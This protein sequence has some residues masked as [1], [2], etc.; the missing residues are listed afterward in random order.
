M[1]T[2]LPL[3]ASFL[4]EQ[5]AAL[6]EYLRD[7]D[8]D[9][10]DRLFEDPLQAVLGWP[11]LDV[12]LADRTEVARGGGRCSVSGYYLRDRTPPRIRI[13]DALSMGRRHFTA[14]HE[15]AHHLQPR[16]PKIAPL[17]AKHDKNDPHRTL[18]DRICDAFAAEVLLPDE[19]V[20]T[21]I[22]SAHGPDAE[23]VI[24][25]YRETHASRAA[26]CVRAAQR[27]DHEGWVVL[28]DLDGVVQFAAAANLK[29][30]LAPGTQ[31]PDNSLITRA[32]AIGHQQ[33]FTSVTY[34]SGNTSGEFNTD[35]RTA[36]NFVFTV[37]SLGPTPWTEFPVPEDRRR[38][39]GVESACDH[40]GNEWTDYARPCERCSARICP[41]C[42]RCNCRPSVQRKICQGCWIEQPANAFPD[43]G[44][45][46]ETCIS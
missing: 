42:E 43:G 46:C 23:A 24:R 39:G 6:I 20:D 28:A 5:A 21:A 32:G 38:P 7:D 44:D 16:H 14:L 2:S 12:R 1:S 8:P 34:R 29:Y 25:L 15:L 45:R 11:G 30:H 26:C 10:L 35:A 9:Q 27:I 4:K 22:T 37:L 41:R 19:Q 40:C 33:G 3:N 13:V 36:G 18:E 17:L 31:Q